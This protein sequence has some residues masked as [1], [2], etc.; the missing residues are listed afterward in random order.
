MKITKKVTYKVQIYND[1]CVLLP[2]NGR[3]MP[4]EKIKSE[5]NMYVIRYPPASMKRTLIM[6]WS[7]L[8]RLYA[9]R[10]LVI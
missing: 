2:V 9:V 4:R 3:K 1:L 7:L 6:G 10:S 5:P 8:N